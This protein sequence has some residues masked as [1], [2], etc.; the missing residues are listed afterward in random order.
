MSN[1]CNDGHKGPLIIEKVGGLNHYC[2]AACQHPISYEET[3]KWLGWQE[4][5]EK[6][7]TN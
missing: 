3:I 1:E 2:C 4:F 5:L 7:D 6:L